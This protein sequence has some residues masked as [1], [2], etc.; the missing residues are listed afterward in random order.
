MVI[1]QTLTAAQVLLRSPPS[2]SV[3]HETN[4]QKQQIPIRFRLD[5]PSCALPPKCPDS[6][7]TGLVSAFRNGSNSTRAGTFKQPFGIG[8]GAPAIL[9]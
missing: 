6:L 3:P 5:P 8:I 4:F 9:Q 2:S 7:K 1:I